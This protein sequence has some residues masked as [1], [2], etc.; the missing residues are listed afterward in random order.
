MLSQ[1]F[2][3]SNSEIKSETNDCMRGSWK[4]AAGTTFVFMLISITLIAL[5]VLPSVFVAW[6]FSIPFAV[7]A[8]LIFSI[9][10]YGY[11]EYCLNLA[12]QENPP[13]SML[14]SGFSKKIGQILKLEIK[15]IILL[16]M[17]LVVFVIPFF[18]KAAA[19]SMATHLMIDKG[20]KSATALKESKHIM[21]QNYGRFFKF[22]IS[23][24]LWFMLAIISAGIALIWI[25]PKFAV[26]K[27]L[28]YENLKT[29]F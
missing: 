14:F 15:K 20:E 28:F 2:Y 5:I 22:I 27:S 23:Y 7:L 21:T 26:G 10:H 11:T 24:F 16:L 4:S 13:M 25:A 18:V 9:F 29:E 6:W 1:G 12:R 8:I 17:W 3:I 19:Y